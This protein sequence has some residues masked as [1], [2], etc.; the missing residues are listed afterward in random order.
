MKHI[1]T[2]G[3]DMDN[4]RLLAIRGMKGKRG[5]C[6]MFVNYV[7]GNSVRWTP[8]V[9]GFGSIDNSSE[10]SVL[11]LKQ[12]INPSQSNAICGGSRCHCNSVWH[13][14]MDLS[15]CTGNGGAEWDV[16]AR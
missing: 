3:A 13:Q 5:Y 7:R 14:Q 1:E 11:Y 10:G 16:R 9:F 4:N 15:D 12:R 6:E 2:M 8:L